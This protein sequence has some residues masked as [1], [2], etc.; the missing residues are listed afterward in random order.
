[1]GNNKL[2]PKAILGDLTQLQD[3]AKSLNDAVKLIGD[4]RQRLEVVESAVLRI[5]RQL[6]S[7]E[8]R[9]SELLFTL[10]DLKRR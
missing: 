2:S 7:L 6:E 1:M 9:Y 5:D 4:N 10:G 3:A 8:R